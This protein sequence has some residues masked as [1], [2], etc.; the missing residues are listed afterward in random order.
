MKAILAKL[1]EIVWTE[2]VKR[3]LVR[4]IRTLVYLVAAALIAELAKQPTLLFLAP[5][6]T[7]ADKFVRDALAQ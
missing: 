6:F 7:A 2:N 5:A 4:G 1:K 3:A